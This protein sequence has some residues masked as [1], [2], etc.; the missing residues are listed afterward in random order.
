MAAVASRDTSPE[1]CVRRLIHR[2]GFRFRLHRVDLPGKP[3][4]VLPRLQTVVFVHG[5]FWHRHVCNAGRSMPATNQAYWRAK[6]ERNIRRD[7]KVQRKLKAEGWNVIVVWECQTKGEQAA[8]L[9]TRL[10]RR[11]AARAAQ[12][13]ENP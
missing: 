8:R 4:I 2:L 9:A 10:H 6:F 13:D 7:R 11:L 12:L 5:C 3:D 1:I